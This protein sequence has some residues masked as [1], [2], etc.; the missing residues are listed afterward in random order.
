M[1]EKTSKTVVDVLAVIVIIGALLIMTGWIFGIEILKTPNLS[2]ISTK[3][4]TA[5]SF[6]F[7]G[8]LLLQLNKQMHSK[9]KEFNVFLTLFLSTSI[10]FLMFSM[11]LTMFFKIPLGVE[12]LFLK[13]TIESSQTFY[14]GMPAIPT[15]VSF[16]VV[17]AL[18][19]ATIFSTP[20]NFAYGGAVILVLSI[21]SV[22]GYLFNIPLM[23]FFLPNIANPIAFN[24][25]VLFIILGAGFVILQKHAVNKNKHSIDLDQVG[26]SNVIKMNSIMLLILVFSM[27]LFVR[28]HIEMFKSIDT[29]HQILSN[30]IV[31]LEQQIEFIKEV[32]AHHIEEVFP[33]E[34]FLQKNEKIAITQ[35]KS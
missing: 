31:N 8:I 9:N 24:T 35:N 18:T 1:K 32:Q 15:I 6:L 5:L 27:M 22:I 23:Y 28:L 16:F 33:Y 13:D 19:L 26:F 2:W 21:S 3:F 29:E 14:L 4:N 25:A 17:V 34:S 7:S 20:V 10:F 11:F 12:S 30:K